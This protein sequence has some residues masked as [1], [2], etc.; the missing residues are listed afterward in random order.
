[1]IANLKNTPMRTSGVIYQS[2][3]QQLRMLLPKDPQLAGELAISIIELTL[4]G[5]ISSD[6]LTIQLAT[7][8]LRNVI[9]NN[10][11]KYDKTKEVKRQN[12][13]QEY[14]LDIIADPLKKGKSQSITRSK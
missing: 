2:S 10:Q 3:L 7:E 12:K 5:E 6:D 8:N 11:E 9:K 4:T 1:M 13:I 14:K